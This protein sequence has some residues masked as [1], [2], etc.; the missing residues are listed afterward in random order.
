MVNINGKLVDKSELGIAFDNRGLNYGDALF[1]TIRVGYRNIYFWEDHYK[2]LSHSMKIL[3]MKIP[4]NFTSEFLKKEVLKTIDKSSSQANR[5][6]LLV[7][8]KPGGKFTP[9]TQEIDYIISYEILS[10][11]EYS[12]SFSDYEIGLYEENHVTSSVL[13][14]LKTTNRLV[15]VMGSIYAQ[16][17][18][19]HN[20]LLLNEKGTIAEA[21]NGNLFL[22]SGNQVKTPPITD[23]C[24][25]G[26]MRKQVMRIVKSDENYSIVE[27]SISPN[28]LSS[29]DEVFITNVI[30]GII[31]VSKYGDKKY[32]NKL[33]SDLIN[34]LNSELKI[35]N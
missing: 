22:V 5:V 20:C 30:S 7:C 19:F 15:N 35:R 21:L 24:L 12:N 17:N 8:R 33:A 4:D 26:V 18:N 29:A 9:N 10:S 6:K 2:R 23:G 27:E 14:T 13:S 3:K 1:E 31:S 32:T 25:S 28:E 34:R 11:Q 16:E